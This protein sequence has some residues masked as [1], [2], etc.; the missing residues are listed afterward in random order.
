MRFLFIFS[1]VLVSACAS[2]QAKPNYEAKPNVSLDNDYK[3]ARLLQCRTIERAG[4]LIL[5][6]R[7][8]H[9]ALCR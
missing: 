7:E 6:G 8:E 9:S 5:D 1:L 2:Y 3:L 4:L